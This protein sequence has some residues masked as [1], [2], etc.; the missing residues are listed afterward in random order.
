MYHRIDMEHLDNRFHHSWQ[1]G[2]AVGKQNTDIRERQTR[3]ARVRRHRAKKE[4][5]GFLANFM[6][7]NSN[8]KMLNTDIAW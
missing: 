6:F 2:R 5:A 7:N 1:V 3:D 4:N 8:G